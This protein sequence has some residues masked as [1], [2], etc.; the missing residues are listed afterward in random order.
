MCK[1]EILMGIAERDGAQLW[2]GTTRRCKASSRRH[3]P[4]MGPVPPAKPVRIFVAHIP[5]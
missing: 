4:Q 2:S 5:K 3:G 1:A